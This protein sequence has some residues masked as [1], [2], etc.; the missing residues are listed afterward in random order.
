MNIGNTTWREYLTDGSSKE[1]GGATSHE[2]RYFS[3]ITPLFFLATAAL[4]VVL[5]C[6]ASLYGCF[7][8]NWRVIK[9]KNI[10]SIF[11]LKLPLFSNSTSKSIPTVDPVLIATRE[12]ERTIAELE[13]LKKFICSIPVLNTAIQEALMRN[14]GQIAYMPSPLPDGEDVYEH[15]RHLGRRRVILECEQRELLYFLVNDPTLRAVFIR[16]YNQASQDD[17]AQLIKIL[18]RSIDRFSEIEPAY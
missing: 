4:S 11:L 18:G 14:R 13:A 17:K 1:I 6:S 12:E 10:Y 15:L 5:S 2:T 9:E 3:W 16:C 7:K 8:R